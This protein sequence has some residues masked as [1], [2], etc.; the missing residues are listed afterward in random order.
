MEWKINNLTICFFTDDTVQKKF[1]LL[2][3]KKILRKGFHKKH[4]FKILFIDPSVYELRT[5]KE[6]SRITWFT[7]E[8]IENLPPN[9]F[10]SLDYPPDMNTE[11][12]DLFLK[13][14]WK[15]AKMF[16]SCPKAIITV[17]S[18]FNNYQSF[19]EAFDRYL[20]LEI[21]SGILGMGNFCRIMF[22]TE[23]IKKTF[24]LILTCYKEN[25]NIKWIHF[26]GSA[27][28]LIRYIITTFR[29]EDVIV[30]FDSTKWTRACTSELKRRTKIEKPTRIVRLNIYFQ[31][32][33]EQ[34]DKYINQIK[35]ERNI[36]D[37]LEVQS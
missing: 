35:D 27:L 9:T 28:R 29:F 25:E 30:S 17:Q 10:F 4:P 3:I 18:K 24:R 19:K 14:S 20:K 33:V 5:S 37:F 34:I 8:N 1:V 26:Y 22:T 32:Y 21:K 7:K 31:A 16:Q 6:Y 23:F 15:Y 13:K 11:H 12:T 36:F 2:N